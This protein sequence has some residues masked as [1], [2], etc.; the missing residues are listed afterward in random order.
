MMIFLHQN[1]TDFN[2]LRATEKGDKEDIDG[3]EGEEGEEKEGEGEEDD[4]D[5]LSLAWEM[6]ELARAI[7]T[8]VCG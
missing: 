6:L 1:L 5:D 2:T 3:K 7:Y 8:E 4:A